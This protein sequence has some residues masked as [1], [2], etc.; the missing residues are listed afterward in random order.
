MPSFSTIRTF[1]VVLMGSAILLSC[2]KEIDWGTTASDQLLVKVIAKSG[3]SDSVVTIYS[4]NAQRKLIREQAVTVAAGLPPVQTELTINRD[5]SGVI[6]SSVQKSPDLA[7]AG[8][9]SL[10]TRYNYSNSKYTAG[11]FSLTAMGFSFTDSAVYTYDANNRIISDQHF[12]KTALFPLTIPILKNDYSYSADG[13]NVI[14][15]DQS[16]PAAPGGPLAQVSAQTYTHDAKINPLVLLQEAIILNRTNWFNASNVLISRLT[17]TLDPTQ[18]QT[19]DNTYRY[20]T[21]NK[22]DSLFSIQGGLLTTSKFY[23]Q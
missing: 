14:Q 9:D 6:T 21:A 15:Q 16:A 4:Y 8:I 13:K 1:L 23:Y 17:N 2:Q 12:L 19:I 3:V 11:I 5:A 20:N 10:V 7:A 22:P 18:N